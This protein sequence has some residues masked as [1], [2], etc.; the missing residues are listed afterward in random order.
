MTFLPSRENQ[1]YAYC[2][3]ENVISSFRENNIVR[4]FLRVTILFSMMPENSIFPE[5]WNPRSMVTWALVKI[6]SASRLSVNAICIYWLELD[7][8]LTENRWSVEGNWTTIDGNMVYW[9]KLDGLLTE[10][11]RII[12]GNCTFSWRKQDGLDTETGWSIDGNWM[13]NWGKLDGLLMERL[14]SIDGSH[15]TDFHHFERQK[16][17]FCRILKPTV[18]WIPRILQLIFCILEARKCDIYRV[19]KPRVQ[20]YEASCKQILR[21]LASWK[22]DFRRFVKPMFQG[23]SQRVEIFSFLRPE[24]ANMSSQNSIFKD[25]KLCV[26][27]FFAYW[28]TENDISVDSWNQ[29]F[30]VSYWECGN[31]PE[32]RT[33]VSLVPRLVLRLFLYFGGL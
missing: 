15:P 1:G 31:F 28:W 14:K 25:A 33:H 9:W 29:C 13:V 7:G 21:I 20:W 26:S 8:L 11:G 12:D 4:T 5:S 27:K 23:T 10:T 30:K 3:T 2:W 19:V 6:F 22:C 17:R 32:S 18:S 16:M 24:N